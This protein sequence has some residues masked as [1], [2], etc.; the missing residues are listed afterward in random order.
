MTKFTGKNMKRTAAV[1]L[2]SV[3]L[4]LPALAQTGST[5]GAPPAAQN[6]QGPPPGGGGRR[7]NPEQRLERMTKELSL[8]ADQQ[9]KVKAILEDGRAK[10]MAARDPNASQDDRRAKMMELRKTES[11]HI[12]AVLDDGQKAKF[13]EMQKREMERMRDGGGRGPGGPP[14]PASPQP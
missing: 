1:L 7:G 9:V 10:M 3:S 11:D 5:D 12:K 6:Q 2:C 4:V 8:S 14:P 13:D